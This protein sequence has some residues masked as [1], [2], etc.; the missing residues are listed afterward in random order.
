MRTLI[1]LLTS[2][3][4]AA[5]YSQ[6]PNYG[7]PPGFPPPHQTPMEGQMCGGMIGGQCANQSDYCYMP[8]SAR[9]GAADASGVCRPRPQMCTKEYAPVCGCGDRTYSNACTAAANGVSVAYNGPC[10][11]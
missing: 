8:L 9:C 10:R 5:C 2:I 6:P 4:L 11:R 3:I 7:P 1:I